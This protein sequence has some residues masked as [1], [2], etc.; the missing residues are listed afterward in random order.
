[1]LPDKY[2]IV[3]AELYEGL[4][5]YP[6]KVVLLSN[7]AEMPLLKDVFVIVSRD[8]FSANLLKGNV[9]LFLNT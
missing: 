7:P 2:A 6:P 3:G 5:K 4:S 1:M 8:D 9:I